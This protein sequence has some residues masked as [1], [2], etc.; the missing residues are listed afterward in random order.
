[1]TSSKNLAFERQLR[2][3]LSELISEPQSIRIIAIDTG[4]NPTSINF[5]APAE[6]IWQS[7]V[8]EARA[9]DLLL[10]LLQDIRQR[11][12]TDHKL[13]DLYTQFVSGRV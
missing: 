2:T 10:R 12:P 4:L 9:H 8:V 7:V 3:M 6:N 13:L 5:D 1:M 11:F